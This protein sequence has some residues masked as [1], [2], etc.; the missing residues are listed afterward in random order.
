MGTFCEYHC[1]SVGMVQ[2]LGDDE[3]ALGVDFA[4]QHSDG[5]SVHFTGVLLVYSDQDGALQGELE[6]ENSPFV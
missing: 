1:D 2:Y 3:F 4:D 6:V 5:L